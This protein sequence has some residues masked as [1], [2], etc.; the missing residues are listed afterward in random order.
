MD[1][2]INGRPFPRYPVAPEV[3]HVIMIDGADKR[4]NSV[5]I[6]PTSGEIHCEA[7]VI[8]TPANIG[9]QDAPVVQ[10]DTEAKS[11]KNKPRGRRQNKRD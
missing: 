6:D 11:T 5:R 3:G 9:N 2:K 1:V 7:D 8:E 10:H 4:I